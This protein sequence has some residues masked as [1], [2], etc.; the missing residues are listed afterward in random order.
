MLNSKSLKDY[1]KEYVDLYENSFI[2]ESLHIELEDLKGE[3]KLE[4]ENINLQKTIL[5]IQ[6][7]K[8]KKE[9]RKLTRVE[10]L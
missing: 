2:F 10:E 7:T 8:D 9:N 3:N 5:R 6:E 1:I 4:L